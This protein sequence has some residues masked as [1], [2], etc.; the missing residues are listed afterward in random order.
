MTAAVSQQFEY[1]DGI[2]TALDQPPC[3]VICGCLSNI[4]YDGVVVKIRSHCT[5]LSRPLV[6]NQVQYFHQTL[7]T[8]RYHLRY[9]EFDESYTS[10]AAIDYRQRY[11]PVF[12]R[13]TTRARTWPHFRDSYL[14]ISERLAVP[15]GRTVTN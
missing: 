8:N 9:P 15:P 5:P 11:I 12:N 4:C 2:S 7:C 6:L 3:I 13:T 14:C 10:R 1:E